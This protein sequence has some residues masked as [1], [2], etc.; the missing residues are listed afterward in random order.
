MPCQ[1]HP[2]SRS[3][4]LPPPQFAARTPQA[5]VSF[6]LAGNGRLL[7]GRAV[8]LHSLGPGYDSVL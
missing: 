1:T 3:T 8:L 2:L 7:L 5:A 6:V 4:C